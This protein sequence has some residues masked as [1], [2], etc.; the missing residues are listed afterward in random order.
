M[1]SACKSGLKKELAEL[2]H[3]NTPLQMGRAAGTGAAELG[4]EE[5]GP[6]QHRHVG[7]AAQQP[8]ALCS[9]QESLLS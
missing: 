2:S 1:L 7:G 4:Q 3:R 9:L 5:A 6:A 8:A